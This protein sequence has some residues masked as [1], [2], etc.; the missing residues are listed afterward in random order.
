MST[1]K[2]SLTDVMSLLVI[3]MTVSNSF[4][5]LLYYSYL[6]RLWDLRLLVRMTIIIEWV[7]IDGMNMVARVV[8]R[9]INRIFVG[10]P[11]CECIPS[12]FRYPP[13]LLADSCTKLGR[14]DDFM[15]VN[16]EH[17]FKLAKARHTIERFP[18]FM[19]E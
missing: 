8:F 7:S 16:I 15:Q 13:T 12:E 10:L 14:N 4:Y 18:I 9:A 5:L 3:S 17:A 2:K 11:F 19:R 1:L 6:L